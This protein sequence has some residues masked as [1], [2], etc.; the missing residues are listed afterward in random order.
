MAALTPI[1]RKPMSMVLPSVALAGAFAGMFVGAGNGSIALGILGGA[2]LIA[3][4]AWVYIT[5]LKNEKLARWINILGFGIVGFLISGPMG[6]IL[7]CWEGGSSSSLSTGC[8]KAVT[9][10]NCCPT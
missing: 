3:A 6:G 8:T 10:A 9:A 5:V 1:S 2:V 7:G 4:L